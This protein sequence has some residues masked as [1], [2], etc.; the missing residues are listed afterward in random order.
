MVPIGAGGCDRD[1]I[2]GV[3]V[4]SHEEV[5]L[6]LEPL[7][8]EH[9]KWVRRSVANL[10]ILGRFYDSREAAVEA[11]DISKRLRELLDS[12]ALECETMSASHK[13]ALNYAAMREGD[14][15]FS[16]GIRDRVAD[17]RNAAVEVR[18]ALNSFERQARSEALEID[19]ATAEARGVDSISVGRRNQPIPQLIADWV[20][21][22]H[23]LGLGEA[24]ECKKRAH[25]P[26][27][28]YE[29]ALSDMLHAF[30]VGSG[31][32]ARGI[33]ALRKLDPDT[34]KRLQREHKEPDWLR[35]QKRMEESR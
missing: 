23:V 25:G 27:S 10:P 9:A 19:R 6:I 2:A 14:D 7:N 28:K 35:F 15:V 5:G 33:V 31:W 34:L 29:I 12:L 24:P 3:R 17:L 20:A 18:D 26:L 4:P 1:W 21:L 13:R 30:G 8:F 16:K 22:I 11:F 32:Y